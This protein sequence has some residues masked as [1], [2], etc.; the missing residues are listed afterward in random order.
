M[1]QVPEPVFLGAL[2]RIIVLQL[3]FN[4]AEHAIERNRRVSIIGN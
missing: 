3:S 1:K 2:T 4:L